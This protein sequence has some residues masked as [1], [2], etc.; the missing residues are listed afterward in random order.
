MEALIPAQR[1]FPKVSA[2][3]SS[4]GTTANS[5]RW[6]VGTDTRAGSSLQLLGANSWV[7]VG[8]G[9]EAIYTQ[10]NPESWGSSASRVLEGMC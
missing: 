5:P 6:V 4:P 8:E 10:G 7:E 9:A 3:Q 1:H 2:R